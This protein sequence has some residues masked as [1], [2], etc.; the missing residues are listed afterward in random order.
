VA[1]CAVGDHAL[2]TLP[3]SSAQNDIKQLIPVGV[4]KLGE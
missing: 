2:G 1:V 4:P 3:R